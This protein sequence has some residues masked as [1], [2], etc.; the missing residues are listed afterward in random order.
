MPW[1]HSNVCRM[2]SQCV[3]SGFHIAEHVPFAI[4][5]EMVAEALRALKPAGLLILETP[6]AENLVVGASSFY[7]DPT[8]R[9]P[10]PPLLL[11]FLTEYAGFSRT[12]I[13]RLQESP[14]LAA[15]RARVTLLQ[16]LAG[17]SPDYAV[18]AQ[19]TASAEALAHFSAPFAQ[20]YGLTLEA[21][22]AQYESD[23]RADLLRELRPPRKRAA[24]AKK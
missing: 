23:L 12:K 1:R 17:V 22:A 2:A 3:V 11:S 9:R 7:L 13:L 15:H 18:V 5:Q 4:L 16:V 8:H 10:L 14:E 6:N 24:P 19:K 21:L 20:E